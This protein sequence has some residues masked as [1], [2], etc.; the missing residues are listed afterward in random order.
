ME[1]GSVFRKKY[2]WVMMASVR[3]N[4]LEEKMQYIGCGGM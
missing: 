2:S 1:G 4:N 3:E